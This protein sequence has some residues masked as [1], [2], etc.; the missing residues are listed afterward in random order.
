MVAFEFDPGKS[1]TNLAKH[2]IDFVVAQNL[3]QVIG[4][5]QPSPF[6]KEVRLRRT[7]LYDGKCW[8]A[9][10]TMRGLNI[11][12]ISVRRARTTEVT[13]YEQA[14]GQDPG[15]DLEP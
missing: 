4:W 14:V 5:E 10:Y 9:V 2:G 12:L 8:T 15:T 1:A 3:W 7:A 13:S 11:R 6:V